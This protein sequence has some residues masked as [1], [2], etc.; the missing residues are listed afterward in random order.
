ML[1]IYR[2]VYLLIQSKFS[3]LITN[4][5]FVLFFVFFGGG[6]GGDF[7]SQENK[8]LGYALFRV[9]MVDG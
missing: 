2:T 4:S 9:R 3:L 6:G 1:N 5:P 8:Q 7:D